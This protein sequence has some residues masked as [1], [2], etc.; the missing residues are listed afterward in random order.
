MQAS[1]AEQLAALQKEGDA[2]C[3]KLRG[4][5][6]L[7]GNALSLKSIDICWRE[8]QALKARL[9]KQLV[10]QVAAARQQM[11][12]SCG[13]VVAANRRFEETQLKTFAG[14]IAG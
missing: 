3:I 7:L 4:Y 8:A 9:E 2:M 12:A 13:A 5:E 6:R 14:R 10:G 1:F 11:Q